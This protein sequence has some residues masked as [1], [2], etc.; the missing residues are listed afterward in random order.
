MAILELSEE[1]FE[2]A[3]RNAGVLILFHATWNA[4]SQM[5]LPLLE[6]LAGEPRP[7]SVAKVDFDDC[8]ELCLRRGVT[9][10]PTTQFYLGGKL[11]WQRTGLVPGATL[12]Q[13]LAASVGSS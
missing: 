10:I 4:P 1:T 5:M 13:L 6:D 9:S 8:Q 11:A 3:L 7:L 12:R 2:D